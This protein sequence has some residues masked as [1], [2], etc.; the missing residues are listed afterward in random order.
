MP[1]FFLLKRDPTQ[2]FSYEY[3]KIFKNSFFYRRTPVHYT[4]PKFC[5]DDRILW[6]SQGPKLIIFI[7]I[8]SLV[9]LPSQV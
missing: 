2:V 3:C 4:F 1:A 5:C 6:R 9:C 8:V 7:F